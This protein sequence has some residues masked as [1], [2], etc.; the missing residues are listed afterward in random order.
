M[1]TP[2]WDGDWIGEMD[3]GD[4]FLVA[5]LARVKVSPGPASTDLAGAWGGDPG[6]RDWRHF[7]SG[8]SIGSGRYDNVLQPF[9]VVWLGIV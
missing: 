9:P 6:H 3:T 4:R 8:S 5:V 1:L 2:K 7:D